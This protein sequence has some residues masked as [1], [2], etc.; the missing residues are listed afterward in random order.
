[1]DRYIVLISWLGTQ[2]QVRECDG[3]GVSLPARSSP[4]LR[5]RACDPNPFCHFICWALLGEGGLGSGD[6]G[7]AS[8]DT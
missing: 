1:M 6:S 2:L 4:A 7:E 3:E 8:E 5:N